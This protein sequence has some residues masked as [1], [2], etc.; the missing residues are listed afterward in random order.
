M[1]APARPAVPRWL[2]GA[3]ARADA[4][5]AGVLVLALSSVVGLAGV[6]VVGV[7]AAAVARHRAASAAD[8]SAL[9]AAA[10]A[11]RGPEPACAAGRRAAHAVGAELASCTVTGSEV[12]VVAV[13]RPAGALGRL[14]VAR[15]RARAGPA[16]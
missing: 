12:E 16:G 10:Q 11:H 7:G 15:V 1:P 4:G 3:R 9:A 14:G 8:L 2:V 5:V 6:A 13:V